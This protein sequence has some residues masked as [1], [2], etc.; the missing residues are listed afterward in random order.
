MRGLVFACRPRLARNE[1]TLSYRASLASR[2]FKH[3][4][5]YP[6][7]GSKLACG[8]PEG[9]PPIT[10]RWGELMNFPTCPV[11]G[12]PNSKVSEHTAFVNEVLPHR[13]D[14]RA[15]V[16]S[17]AS[18]ER[19]GNDG[20]E[21]WVTPDVKGRILT[22]HGSVIDVAFPGELP[23]LNEA[24]RVV[25][26]RRTLILEVQQVFEPRRVRTI[27]LGHTDGLVRGLAVERTGAV[28]HVPVGPATLG[29]VFDA[30]GEPLDGLAPP[31]TTERWPIHRSAPHT[32]DVPRRML[33][34]VETGIKVIDLLAPVARAG[35]TGIIGGGGVGK[36]IV[37]H[38]LIRTLSRPAIP[39]LA[40][41]G[42]RGVVV[43]AG[44]G[45]RTRE[46]NDLWLDMRA[47]GTL[48]NSIMVLG[49]MSEPAGIRFRV[50]LA[51]LTMAEYFRDRENKEVALLIDS[52]SRHVQAGCEVSA[53]MGRLPSEMGYQP[54]LASELGG[55]EGRIASNTWA[56]ITSV[57]AIYVPADDLTDPVVTGA[58]AHLDTCIIL[59]RDRAAHGLYPAV[60][61]IASN[62]SFLDPSLVGERHHEIAMRVKQTIQRYRELE[63]MIAMLGTQELRSEDQEAVH[64]AR[65]LE[66]FL[67]QPFLSTES[68]TGQPGQSVSLQDT[69]AG[70]EA[71]LSGNFDAVDEHRLYMIG[72]AA[73][74]TQ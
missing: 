54:T 71:I 27:A 40:N 53:L 74:A 31:I 59:S 21:L 58:M 62:S 67:T 42:Q 57:Q 7:N 17:T 19:D 50:A 52:I 56:G 9:R 15:S 64:R 73:A 37:L 69:L 63:D 6:H 65:R 60:D 16:L 38:E 66:R 70:C 5:V 61:P 41:G 3:R 48:A 47:S 2:A 26:G 72:A 44:V 51:A 46:G 36:T 22:V 34:L 10:L 20:E 8:R 4:L 14:P 39:P 25:D 30:F 1:S 29:R 23:Q 24:L 13:L 49:Q 55:L 35:T 28:V 18:L 33:T 12:S 45:E 43:F 11:V 68:L 32:L